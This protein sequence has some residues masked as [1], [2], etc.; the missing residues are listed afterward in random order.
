VSER[1]FWGFAHDFPALLWGK[2]EIWREKIS[3]CPTLIEIMQQDMEAYVK[4][5]ESRVSELQEALKQ[6]TPSYGSFTF[7]PRPSTSMADTRSR[8]GYERRY[9]MLRILPLN[10]CPLC[11][12]I[13]CDA[14]VATSVFAE[15]DPQEQV[16]IRE[17]ALRGRLES[18]VF[19]FDR[20]LFRTPSAPK[21]VI[22]A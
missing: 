2:P 10:P 8:H 1:R 6:Q 9:T 5:L 11:L 4:S 12:S 14:S 3:G 20:C 19:Q 15:A 7:S 17:V 21:S 13:E 18:L 22:A 16:S